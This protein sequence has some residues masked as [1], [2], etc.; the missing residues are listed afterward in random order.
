[1][2]SL[3]NHSTSGIVWSGDTLFEY[4]A[5]PKRFIPGTT[6]NFDGIKDAQKRSGKFT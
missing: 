6:M 2:V 4:L 1:M 5:A 3:I